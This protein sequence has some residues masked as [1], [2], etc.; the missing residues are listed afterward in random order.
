MTETKRMIKKEKNIKLMDAASTVMNNKLERQQRSIDSLTGRITVLEEG[1]KYQRN[2]LE[3]LRCTHERIREEALKFN[4]V[5]RKVLRENEGLTG[6]VNINSAELIGSIANTFL[7]MLSRK[8]YVEAGGDAEEIHKY[9][10]LKSMAEEGNKI[11]IQSKG[12]IE[13]TLIEHKITFA[14]VNNLCKSGGTLAY[15]D[16]PDIDMAKQLVGQ[17]AKRHRASYLRMLDLLYG[18]L[19]SLTLEDTCC[20]KN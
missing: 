15:E 17:V 10:D 12:K 20:F 8:Y 1:Y 9:Y 14:M 11:A 18:E 19:Q 2:H 5:L 4:D 16:I 6:K 13:R 7:E 3:A